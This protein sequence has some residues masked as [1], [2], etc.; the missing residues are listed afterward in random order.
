VGRSPLTGV[1]GPE[2]AQQWLEEPVR[3]H[4]GVRYRISVRLRR[5]QARPGPQDSVLHADEVLA[6]GAAPSQATIGLVGQDA[7][8]AAIVD[9]P[10]TRPDVD[11]GRIGLLGISLGGYYAPRGAAFEKRIT[12]C[13]AWN[14]VWDYGLT[15]SQRG[16]SHGVQRSDRPPGTL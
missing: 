1:P 15:A 4:Q 2:S 6:V 11:P 3:G 14:G 10:Q 13:A 7:P 5:L 8:T 16:A 9:Y 12:A